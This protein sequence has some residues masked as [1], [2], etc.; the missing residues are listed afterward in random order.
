MYALMLSIFW[1]C[2]SA[3]FGTMHTMPRTCSLTADDMVALSPS[4]M[5]ETALMVP[6]M[7]PASQRLNPN[8]GQK[9]LL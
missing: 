5:N 3:N 6:M 4:D 2:P 1:V 8:D 7:R 9:L